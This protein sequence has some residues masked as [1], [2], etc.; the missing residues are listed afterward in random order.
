M[1]KNTTKDIDIN[2]LETFL[3]AGE[4]LERNYCSKF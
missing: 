1:L 4:V 2:Q 3:G